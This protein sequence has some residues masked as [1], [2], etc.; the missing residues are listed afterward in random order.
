MSKFKT[1]EMQLFPDLLINR[2]KKMANEMLSETAEPKSKR[3]NRITQFAHFHQN[4][5]C[6]WIAPG[7]RRPII[8]MH[9]ISVQQHESTAKN[10]KMCI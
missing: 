8:L 4:L 1:L 5:R 7:T 6:G 9:R 3:K 2:K 10:Q